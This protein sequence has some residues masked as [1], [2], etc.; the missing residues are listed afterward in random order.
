LWNMN[1]WCSQGEIYFDLT[2]TKQIFFLLNAKKHF[3]KTLNEKRAK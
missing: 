1:F 3:K 2:L